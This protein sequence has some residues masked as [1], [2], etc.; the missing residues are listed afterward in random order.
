MTFSTIYLPKIAVE[1]EIYSSEKFASDATIKKR[2]VPFF[3]HFPTYVS[4]IFIRII[5]EL[6]GDLEL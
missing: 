6:N 2:L 1:K 4:S 5:K 3:L